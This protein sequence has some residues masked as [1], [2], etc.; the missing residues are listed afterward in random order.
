MTPA[1]TVW[2][3]ADLPLTARHQMSL[4]A[5]ADGRVLMAG[6]V[7]PDAAG[8][9]VL[10]AEIWDPRTGAWSA[11]GDLALDRR[12][13]L[14]VLLTD[15]RVLVLDAETY[16]EGPAAGGTAEVFDPTTGTFSPAGRLQARHGR[17]IGG[18]GWAALMDAVMVALPEGRAL[19]LGGRPEQTADGTG[20]VPAVAEVWDPG[21]GSFHATEPLPCDPS[22]G[23]AAPLPDG[24][25]L[26][27]CNVPNTG[28]GG[29]GARQPQWEPDAVVLDPVAGTFV[30]VAPP[31]TMSTGAA[32]SLPEGRVLL[33]GAAI[34][35]NTDPAEIREPDGTFRRLAS[36]VNPV[37][38]SVVVPLS[39]G[40]VLFLDRSSTSALLFDPETEAF[41]TLELPAP[42]AYGAVA[43]LTDG[44]ALVVFGPDWESPGPRQYPPDPMV[45]DPGR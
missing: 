28:E 5:L 31:T 26:I 36:P 10:G 9:P 2:T 8:T 35:G 19:V 45:L 11:A 27:V 33:T 29:M 44:R 4:V 22:R 13:S 43:P 7:T 23:T 1:P 38:S 37:A 30:R 15:G 42:L 25:V 39:D 21:D 24:T 12:D 3:P 14:A 20:D 41:T 34:A 32:T 6:G 16:G 40:R 18:S 17:G